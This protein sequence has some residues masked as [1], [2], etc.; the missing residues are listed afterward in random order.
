[1]GA[2]LITG[3]MGNIGVPLARNDQS[4]GWISN[5]GNQPIGTQAGQPPPMAAILQQMIAAHPAMQQAPQGASMAPNAGTPATANVPGYHY[6]QSSGWMPTG[7]QQP[8]GLG[9]MPAAQQIA[10]TI[11]QANAIHSPPPSA[12]PGASVASPTGGVNISAIMQALQGNN[13]ASGTMPPATANVPGYRYDQS[14]GWLSNT[15]GQPL[16]VGGGLNN[17]NTTLSQLLAQ[18]PGL[19]AMLSGGTR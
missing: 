11:A 13:V 2:P 17:T 4:S 12:M 15:T 8:P 10:N 18:N 7:A 5:F 3:N 14:S 6:D 9:G 16:V 19:A 1:M